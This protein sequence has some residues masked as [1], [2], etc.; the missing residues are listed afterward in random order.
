MSSA[1]TP[2]PAGPNRHRLA[3]LVL[4]FVYP[5]IT[6]LLYAMGPLTASWQVW[7]RTLV[8]APVMVILMVYVL[9]PFLTKRF[10]AF[11]MGS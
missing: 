4:V 5:L 9:I 8:L 11:L 6:A 1:S 3:L 10:R 2:R 7:E